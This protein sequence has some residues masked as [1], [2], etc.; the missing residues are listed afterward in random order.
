MLCFA[1]PSLLK[2][3]ESLLEVGVKAYCNLRV[4]GLE[5]IDQISN[6]ELYKLRHPCPTHANQSSQDC[7]GFR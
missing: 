6:P 4:L 2:V 7:T 1:S 3:V 5:L